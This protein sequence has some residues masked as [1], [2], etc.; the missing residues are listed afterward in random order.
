MGLN[1]EQAEWQTKKCQQ[2]LSKGMIK[3]GDVIIVADDDKAR[4]SVSWNL[5]DRDIVYWGIVPHDSVYIALPP[6]HQKSV[7]GGRI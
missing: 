6:Y 3:K 4:T 7:G 2:N 5:S 1:Q